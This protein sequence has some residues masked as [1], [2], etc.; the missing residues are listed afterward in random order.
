MIHRIT[1]NN[2]NVKQKVNISEGF[3][4][5]DEETQKN[6]TFSEILTNAWGIGAIQ[7]RAGQWG[8]FSGTCYTYAYKI[9]IYNFKKY[10]KN[11]LP[12]RD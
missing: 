6:N 8:G 10:R 12:H 9:K 4:I 3:T 1:Y 7:H 2:H 11:N 5:S